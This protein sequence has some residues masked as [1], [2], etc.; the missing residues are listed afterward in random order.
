MRSLA[1]FWRSLERFGGGGTV[2]EEWKLL[3]G[4]EYEWVKQFLRSSG[5]L[6]TFF[7]HPD[8]GV[9]IYRVVTHGP[10]D[11]VGICDETGERIVLK[12]ED[13]VLHELDRRA[14]ERE[15]V[16]V[17]GFVA[18][19]PWQRGGRPPWRI[20]QFAPLAGY[21]VP[22]FLTIAHD[23]N[24]LLQA[25]CGLAVGRQSPFILCAPTARMLSKECGQLLHQHHGCFL[26]LA[27]A[28][29]LDQDGRLVAL[30]SGLKAIE[31][32]L[33]RMVPQSGQKS[34]QVFF[35]T[36]AASLWTDVKIRFIDGHTVS[37]AVG[38]IRGVYNFTEM[39]MAN[40]KNGTPTLQ[41]ELLRQFA[42]GRGV[43]TWRSAGADRKN[44]KRRENLAHHLE[45][46]FRIERDPFT[47][48]GN[49]WRAQ[50]Q[51]EPDR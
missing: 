5:E 44:K 3:T 38:D 2:T 28:C 42:A 17:F 46:F 35:P 22:V 19:D 40:R 51:I 50:F 23:E 21:R 27:E 10:D 43:L 20:G 18:E 36:P 34:E 47:R 26:P 9:C 12:T 1:R 49:G 33:R 24:E 31:E 16:R 32:F 29:G 39:G 45:R 8:P 48:Q 6:A 11:H 14:L 25:A 15:L 4:D 41:W 13:L 7:P 37:V 30:Q